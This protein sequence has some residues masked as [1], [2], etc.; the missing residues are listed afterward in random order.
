MNFISRIN[1]Y[2]NETLQER[3]VYWTNYINSSTKNNPVRERM[4]RMRDFAEVV[5]EKRG[6]TVAN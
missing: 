3:I 1:K 6:L 4:I 5:A 2:S